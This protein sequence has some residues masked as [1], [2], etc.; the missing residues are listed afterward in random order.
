MKAQSSK[1]LKEFIQYLRETGKEQAS[2]LYKNQLKNFSKKFDLDNFSVTDV[3][4]FIADLNTYSANATIAALKKYSWYKAQHENYILWSRIRDGMSGLYKK[5]ARVIKKEA[6]TI[7]E[8]ILLVEDIGGTTA[9]AGD[10]KIRPTVEDHL[11]DSCIMLFY[12]GWRPIEI[13]DRMVEGEIDWKNQTIKIIGAKTKDERIV[14]Y[15]KE[16]IEPTL[17]RWLEFAKKKHGMN[18]RPSSW[19]YDTFAN[20][21]DNGEISIKF[22]P[23]MA[24][25]TFQTQ[26]RSRNIAE[27]KIDYLLGHSTR[28]PGVYTDF[29]M[30]VEDLREVM[31][32]KHYLW[33]IL[34]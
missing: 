16:W 14:P 7:E 13:L 29:T 34:P 18:V 6:L 1:N 11:L 27:W 3:E 5:P 33:C 8:I 31:G 4:R 24:R 9:V 10:K 15:H 21:Y 20:R 25:K 19:I 30:M 17:K 12:F 32:E 26:M 22:T 23:K 2:S 28:I